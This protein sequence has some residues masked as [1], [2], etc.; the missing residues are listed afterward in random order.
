MAIRVFLKCS[1]LAK[2]AAMSDA[3]LALVWPFKKRIRTPG[4]FVVLL[5]RREAERLVLWS[6]SREQAPVGKDG[7]SRG[8][9][10]DTMGANGCPER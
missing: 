4:V 5:M 6:I 8:P 2:I 7:C 10:T 3:V 9:E 1:S